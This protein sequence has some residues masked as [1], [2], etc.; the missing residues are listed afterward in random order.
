MAQHAPPPEPKLA[1]EMWSREI[2]DRLDEVIKLLKSQNATL[3]GDR[4]KTVQ[5]ELTE[6]SSE[7][8]KAKEEDKSTAKSTTSST[9]EEDKPG[10][11]ASARKTSTATTPARSTTAAKK[12]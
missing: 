7:G 4:A 11:T 12:D 8:S 10:T 1:H 2:C 6:P 9:K 5:V 3:V